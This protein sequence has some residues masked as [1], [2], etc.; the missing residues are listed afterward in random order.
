V[1]APELP[2]RTRLLLLRLGSALLAV[3]QGVIGGWALL[4]PDSFFRAFPGA[5]VGWVALL[6]PYN[7]HLV[8]DVGA[9]SLALAVLLGYAAVRPDPRIVR[10]AVLA[11]AVY[12]VPHT[13]YHA[14]HLT[15]YP[16]ADVTVQVTGFALQLAL[17]VVLLLATLPRRR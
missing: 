5:G 1:S 9:L 10:L 7:E 17:V 4:G 14:G 2:S 6:P 8:R 16:A 11:F 12:A 3:S 15:G 13:V